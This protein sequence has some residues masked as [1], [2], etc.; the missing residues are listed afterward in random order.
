VDPAPFRLVDRTF[1][2]VQWEAICRRCGRCCY[3]KEP[4]ADGTVVYHDTHCSQ[5]GDDN[6]CAV[7]ADRFEA[8]PH[9]N[10]VTAAV[11]REGR[12]IPASCA[13]VRLYE[14]L[15]EQLEERLRVSRRG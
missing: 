15:L 8:E 6:E 10:Q 14:E 13:Y 5:L 3:E 7:Y 4:L 1:S 2:L 12:I 11:V 9:C